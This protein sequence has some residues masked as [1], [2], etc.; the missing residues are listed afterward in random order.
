M[1]QGPLLFVSLV[2]LQDDI[3]EHTIDLL[4]LRKFI[5]KHSKNP[6]QLQVFE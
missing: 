4:G 2:C 6:K 5:D 1:L 3:R